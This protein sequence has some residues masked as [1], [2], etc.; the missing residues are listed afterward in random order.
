M[1]AAALRRHRRGRR[2]ALPAVLAAVAVTGCGSAA[3]APS[4]APR[5]RATASGQP[6]SSGAVAPGTA[7]TVLAPLGLRLR[8]SASPGGTVL[9]SLGQGTTVTVVSHSDQN[10]GWYEVKG[11][12]QTG[13]ITDDPADTSPRRFELYQSDAH[14]FS[15]LYLDSWSFTEGA[16]A[17]VFHPQN[18]VYPQITVTSGP[19][20]DALGPPGMAG[21]STVQAGS[22]EV[23]GITGVL[24]LLA[25]SGSPSPAPSGQPP[26]P[27]LL[28]E[29]RV[30]LDP[31]RAMRLD[32]LYATPD[33]LTTFRDFSN[34]IV[35]PTP[36]T[37]A[38]GAAPRPAG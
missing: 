10:G 15:A 21:Y 11:E 4:H 18:G 17:V 30:T 1:T 35:V 22:A 13:W 3:P 31:H 29:L 36:A 6:P 7:L 26:L 32:Y 9:G 34:S 5:A 25:R 19:S 23:Y 2:V 14:G 37:P 33:E 24:R 28:A 20:L 12:T 16:T 27:P 8:D 38:P